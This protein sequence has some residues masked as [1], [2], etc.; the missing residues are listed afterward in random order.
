MTRLKNVTVQI[1]YTKSIR[2]RLDSVTLMI[3]FSATSLIRG[4]TE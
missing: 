2:Y 4:S 1:G 3:N